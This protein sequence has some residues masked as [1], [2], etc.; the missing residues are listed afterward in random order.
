LQ[1][2]VVAIGRSMPNWI[3]RGWQEYAHR[4]PSQIALEL[5]EVASPRQS[6]GGRQ[7]REGEALLSRCP[8]AGP[9]IALDEGGSAW[10]TRDLAGRLN[11]WLM[12]GEPVTLLVGG[13]SGHSPH[14]LAQCTERWSLGPL[15]FPHMLVR[16]IVGEQVYRAWTLLSGHPYHRG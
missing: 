10:S 12:R 14:L 3:A 5:I 15:T 11:D 7:R 16:V 4:M 2:R 1:I 6:G 13:A 9:R 8:R